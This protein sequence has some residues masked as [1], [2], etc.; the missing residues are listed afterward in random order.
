MGRKVDFL[1]KVIRKRRMPNTGKYL[2]LKNLV[3]NAIPILLRHRLRSLR[4][5]DIQRGEP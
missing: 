2:S 5:S 3:W 1:E 4:I